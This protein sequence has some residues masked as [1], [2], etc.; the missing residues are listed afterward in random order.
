MSKPVLV[1][2]LPNQRK[3]P[4]CLGILR[5]PVHFTCFL[6]LLDQVLLIQERSELAA[7]MVGAPVFR[8]AQLSDLDALVRNNIAMAVVRSTAKHCR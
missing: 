4:L 3:Q 6:P 8:Q 2:W 7:V 1:V 5:N